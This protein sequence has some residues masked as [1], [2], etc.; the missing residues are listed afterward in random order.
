MNL[1]PLIKYIKE[2]PT[3]VWVVL[4]LVSAI[5][6]THSLRQNNFEMIQLRSAVYAA[7]KNGQNVEGALNNLRHYVYGH[8][9]TN[10]SSGGNAITPPIQL[11]YSYDRLVNTEQQRVN[12]AND[13]IYRQAQAYCEKTQPGKYRQ[14]CFQQYTDRHNV[15]ADV[16]PA[17]LYQFDFISPAWSPDLAGWSLVLSSLLGLAFIVNYLIDRLAYSK[18]SRR[19]RF[20]D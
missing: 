16:V 7:D 9:N 18:L 12:Q 1:R 8:M 20:R 14:V 15:K 13:K 2:T 17:A 10:L 19:R 4:F 6:T 11:K 3:W 5:I